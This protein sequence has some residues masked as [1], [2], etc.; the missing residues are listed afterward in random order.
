MDVSSAT[1]ASTAN[2][3]TQVNN[4][5]QR[6]AQDIQAQ[7][8]QQLINSLPQTQPE[9]DPTATVGSQVNIFA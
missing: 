1:S 4:E 9:P 6:R 3:H 7:N 8:A 2:L 5:V